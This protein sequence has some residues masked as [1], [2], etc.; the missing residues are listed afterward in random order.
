MDTQIWVQGALLVRSGIDV[1]KTV[2]GLLP[3]RKSGQDKIPVYRLVT[4]DQ[5][6]L[7]R[8]ERA[9]DITDMRWPR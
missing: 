8:S 5:L 3:P 1:V 4:R 2:L 6:L 9:T 7:A